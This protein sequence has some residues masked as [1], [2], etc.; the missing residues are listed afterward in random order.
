MMR[1]VAIRV[2]VVPIMLFLGAF[3]AN[4][5]TPIS[6]TATFDAAGRITAQHPKNWISSSSYDGNTGTFTVKFAGAGFSNPPSCTVGSGHGNLQMYADNFPQVVSAS[7]DD[8]VIVDS[9]DPHPASHTAPGF[10]LV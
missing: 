8:L 1:T 4:A 7:Q 10:Q 3:S 9:L 6:L 5:A 2:L